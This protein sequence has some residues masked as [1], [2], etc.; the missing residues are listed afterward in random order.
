MSSDRSEYSKRYYQENKKRIEERRK[1]HMLANPEKWVARYR[2]YAEKNKE[3]LRKYRQE[4]YQK[5]RDKIIEKGRKW[6]RGNKKRKH[7]NY[8]SWRDRFLNM[9]G[10]RCSCCGETIV[11]F[12][13][14]EHIQG[15]NDHRAKRSSY[16]DYRDAIQEY[17]PDI[18]EVLCM[19]CNHA[20]GRF[21]FCPHQ[22]LTIGMYE[23]S[24]EESKTPIQ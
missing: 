21:G 8:M 24:Q 15:R 16:K 6:S 4:Y 17:Q 13:T 10:R 23:N 11:E 9:Y 1:A 22:K 3:K 12:L 20:K 19:N 18:Y 2:A 14:I 5:N 7:E